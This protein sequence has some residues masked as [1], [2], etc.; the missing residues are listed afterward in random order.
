MADKEISSV[1][2]VKV[3]D[4]LKFEEKDK[5]GKFHYIGEVIKVQKE[6]KFVAP[7]IEMQTFEG[8][9]GFTFPK[10]MKD[11]DDTAVRPKQETQKHLLYLTDTKPTGWSK[12]KKDP[13]KYLDSKKEE[14]QIVVP[15]KTK[16]ER[17]FE[18]VA[19]NPR[20]KEDALLKLAKKEI[21]GTDNQLL[22]YIK[23][24]L[25]KK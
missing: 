23:L 5:S 1:D 9:M 8:V 10:T 25:S 7:C 22:S 14:E 15:V 20:K 24:A 2:E 17:V 12:F 16:K 21:G 6:S 18:L 3:G 13:D 19:A 4:F 11:D